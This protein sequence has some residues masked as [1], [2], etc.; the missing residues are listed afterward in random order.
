MSLEIKRQVK[1]HHE[2]LNSRVRREIKK[3]LTILLVV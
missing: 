2:N 1:V 3:D